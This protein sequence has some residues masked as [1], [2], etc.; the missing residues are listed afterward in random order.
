MITLRVAA[1]RGVLIFKNQDLVDKGPD[2]CADFG[3]HFGPLHHHPIMWRVKDHM[4]LQV[5]YAG[6]EEG[7]DKNYIEHNHADVTSGLRWHSDQ[8]HEPQPPSVTMLCALELPK[9]GSGGDTLFSSA[10]ACYNA[11]SPEFRRMIDP[12][13]WEATSKTQIARSVSIG[14]TGRRQGMSVAHPVVIVHP[15][16]GDRVSL[17]HKS[18]VI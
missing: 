12:L 15:V 18:R 16:T 7:G 14:A 11:L 10:V 4:D 6:P 5:V 8:M 17:H 9:S 2:A 3:R 1:K 13:W